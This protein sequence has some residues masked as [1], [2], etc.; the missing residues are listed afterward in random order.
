VAGAGTA[1]AMSSGHRVEQREVIPHQITALSVLGRGG[2]VTVRS[3]AGTDTVQVLRRG[4]EAVAEG[5][6]FGAP[7]WD[8]TQL[9]LQPDCTGGCDVDYVVTVP[10]GVAVTVRTDSGD[11]EVRG[12][13]GPV[14]LETRSG[15][16]DADV[17]SSTVTVT[18]SGGDA[19]LRL[20]QAPDQL[21]A[22]SGSGDVDIRVP[23][24]EVYAVTP[25]TRSGDVDLNVQQG[26]SGHVIQVQT[27][28]GDISVEDG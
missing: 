24:G 2:D 4:T 6:V 19:D 8:G 7:S 15:D 5:A 21:S 12:R 27:Q 20:R 18:T 28:S 14:A 10:D 9:Q 17:T 1:I 23:G 16:I 3:G 25:D 13:L 26:P 22:R 11:V